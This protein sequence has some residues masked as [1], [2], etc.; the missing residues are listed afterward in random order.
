MRQLAFAILALVGSGCTIHVVEQPATPVLMAEAPRAVVE[1]PARPHHVSYEPV[2]AAPL[3]VPVPR[4]A[5][6]PHAAQPTGS[7]RVPFRTLPPETR[8][9][10][11]ARI[12][13]PT[14]H[15]GFEKRERT[16]PLTKVSS[17]NVA[18]AQ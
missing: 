2:A 13:P 17:T 11:L 4:R 12:A 9:A 16:V 10:H 1:G 14:R 15:R 7:P 8:N 18:K 6:A 5:P 3:P